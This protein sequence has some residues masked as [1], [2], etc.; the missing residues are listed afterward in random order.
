MNDDTNNNSSYGHRCGFGGRRVKKMLVIVFLALAIFLVAK[1]INTIKEY[2]FIGG[3]VSATNMISVSGEGEVFAVPDIA[4]F[5]FSVVEEKKTVTDAQEAVAQRINSIIAFLDDSNVKETDI[6]TIN[7]NV[8]PRYEF[9]RENCKGGF[10]P[11]A[12]ER[13]LKGFEVNQSIS[14]KVRDT[15]EAGS[16]LAGIG[17]RGATNISGLN[18]TIDDEE[19][20]LEEARKKAID[21]A[22]KKA[23]QLAKDL[24]VK[25]VR[26][27]SFSESGNQP[28]YKNYA[29][30]EIAIQDA[31]GGGAPEIPTGE[32]KITSNVSITYEIR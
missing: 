10:C 17:E 30:A 22:R 19:A 16:I 25:L 21:N 23:K 24:D 13:V 6:K 5:S 26:V 2:R 12:G 4:E 14:V 28:Y 7:Y 20:L 15:Q 11:P 8:Y 18:F 29:F 32:N 9:I 1:T 31:V 3:G 27:V